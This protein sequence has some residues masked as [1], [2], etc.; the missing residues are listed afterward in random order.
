MDF[1]FYEILGLIGALGYLLSY[2]LLQLKRDYA[3]TISYSMM[4]LVSA[5]LVAV[6]L[7][8]DFNLGSMFIQVMWIIISAYG[9]YRCL[10]Y[11]FAESTEIP[12]LVEDAPDNQHD[13]TA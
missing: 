8:K 7:T 1:T 9:I 13:K 6:S 12:P 10:K 4:N 2:A 5:A 3:K 11:K